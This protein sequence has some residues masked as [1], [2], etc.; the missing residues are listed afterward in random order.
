MPITLVTGTP[1]AGKTLYTLSKLAPKFLAEKLDIDGTKRE[2]TLHVAGVRD[3]MIEHEPIDRPHITEWETYRDE[4]SGMQRAPGEPPLDVPHRADNW[5]LWCQPGDVIIVDEAQYVFRPAAA[6]RK[7]PKFVDA[8]NVHRHYGVDFVLI[9][10]GPQ[11]IHTIAR[12]LVSPHIHIRRIF[13][14]HSCQVLEWDRASNVN[15]AKTAVQ[16]TWRHDKKAYSVYKSAEVHTKFS[17]RIPY[18]AIALGLAVLLLPFLWYRAIN[19]TLGDKPPAE[20]PAAVGQPLTQAERPAEAEKRPV[21]RFIAARGE[22]AFAD[23]VRARQTWPDAVAGC[24]SDTEGNCSCVTQEQPPRVITDRPAMC[25]AIMGGDL[26]PPASHPTPERAEPSQ[27]QQSAG[28]A[29]GVEA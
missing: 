29:S 27:V 15:Q 21:A 3:L 16:R 11:L 13:G 25:L 14:S 23:A 17:Q 9:T 1:G 22:P 7:L 24:W 5:H 2:R 20:K 6:G 4:W 18:A 26:V 28:A 19:R 8:L 12:S 10:Q